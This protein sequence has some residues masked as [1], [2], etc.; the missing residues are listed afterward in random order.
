MAVPPTRRLPRLALPLCILFCLILTSPSARAQTCE[1]WAG[2]M[3]PLNGSL[4][5]TH[6]SDTDTIKEALSYPIIALS[7]C[8]CLAGDPPECAPHL[9]GRVVYLFAPLTQT[10]VADQIR[11]L[12]AQISQQ[13]A[14]L[15]PSCANASL[16]FA[17]RSAFPRCVLVNDTITGQE[18]TKRC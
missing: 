8:A 9:Q 16:P 2:A 1:L 5:D 3:S 14:L 15:A 17:C 11:N 7:H 12:T 4:H 13:V 10:L 6:T 18:G